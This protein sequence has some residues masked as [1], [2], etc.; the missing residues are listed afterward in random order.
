MLKIS[1][2]DSVFV[3]NSIFILPLVGLGVISNNSLLEINEPTPDV[4][5]MQ[6]PLS[7]SALGS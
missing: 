5:P 6:Q 2:L 4:P 7:Q 1:T 3:E